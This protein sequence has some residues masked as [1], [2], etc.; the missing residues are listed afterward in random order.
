LVVRNVLRK[1]FGPLPI[2]GSNL[3]FIVP[4][5]VGRGTQIGQCTKVLVDERRV[6]TSDARSQIDY[7]FR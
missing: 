4:T 1:P 3:F 6:F 7:I 2:R 5:P